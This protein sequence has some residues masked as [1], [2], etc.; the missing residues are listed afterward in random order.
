MVGGNDEQVILNLQGAYASDGAPPQIAPGQ[1]LVGQCY[2]DRQRI[3]L[4]EIPPGYLRIH[5]ALG[6]APPRTIVVQPALFEDEVLAVLELA[7]LG[8]PTPTQLT[9]LERVAESLAIVLSTIGASQRTEE[10]LVQAQDLSAELRVQQDE[11]NRKNRELE[12]QTTR[13]RNSELLLQEQQEELKQTNE[14]LEQTNEELQQTNEEIEEKVNLLAVQKREA[15]KTSVE[16][17]RARG[18]LQEK[19]EQIAQTSKYKS[20][21]LANMSHELRTPLNS[22][23]ILSKDAGRQSPTPP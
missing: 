22:L 14:E 1:G 18:A 11:L 4:S 21:F 19:A 20:E 15:E 7:L 3:Q 12:S 5:S 6:E 9:L 17:E 2:L 23:L 8:D 10:L 13:L 16:I